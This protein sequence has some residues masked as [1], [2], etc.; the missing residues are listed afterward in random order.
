MM[1]L[2]FQDIAHIAKSL[3]KASRSGQNWTCLC[4][5]HKDRMPSLS[6]ALGQDGQL[7]L[8][9]YAGC[10]FD[11]ILQELHHKRLLEN[12]CKNVPCSYRPSKPP[13][14]SKV[15]DFC[16]SPASKPYLKPSK[17]DPCRDN[18]SI[19][20]LWESS[21]PAGNTAVE[22]YLHSRGLTVAIPPTLRYLPDHL[23][24]ATKTRWPCMV[25]AIICWPDRLVGIHRTY[26]K[27][28]GLSKAS[29]DPNKM[30]L[31]QLR[32]GCVPLLPVQETLIIAEG[33][34]TALSVA[35][36]SPDMGVWA[37][38]SATNM[39]HLVL[40][41]LPL[42]QTIIIAADPDEAGIRAAWSSARK[43]ADEGRL[44][45][46]ALPAPTKDFNDILQEMPH[47]PSS[48]QKHPGLGGN[49]QGRA[50]SAVAT[51]P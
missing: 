35:L 10:S 19:A 16:Q 29:V 36:A 51:Y 18:P 26:I 39:P 23:H 27:R 14:P 48:N 28:D 4:P 33:I 1:A 41:P 15:V 24:A 7:L 37:A 17:V 22:R 45:K 40:P 46:I 32:G 5:A 47:D 44:V 21:K 25:G 34:E 49:S 13:K 11:Q 6:M 38:L 3:G 43:W 2:T 12:L 42:A 31:G 30:M 8:H 20:R 50:A 9:C